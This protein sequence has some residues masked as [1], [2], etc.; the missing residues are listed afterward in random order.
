LAVAAVATIAVVRALTA[1]HKPVLPVSWCRPESLSTLPPMLGSAL[2]TQWHVDVI[3]LVV[4]GLAGLLYA[5]GVVLARRA[6]H[7]WPLQRGVGFLCGLVVCALATNS[8]IAVYDMA[9]FSA[10]MVGHLMLVMLAPVLLCIGR[11][12]ELLVRASADPWSDRLARFFGGRV[13]S[14]VLC[15]PVALATYAAVIVTS[16]LTG[17]MDQ[18]M[19]RPWAGQLEH[20]VYVLV[21]MQFFTLLVGDSTIRWQLTTAARWLLLVLSMAVDTSTGVVLMMSTQPVAMVAVPGFDVNPLADT[22]TAGAIMWVGGDG[23]M[24]AVM[25]WLTISF[26]RQPAMR[27]RD[28]TGL[29]EQARQTVFAAHTGGEAPAVADAGFDDE[30]ANRERYNRWLASLDNHG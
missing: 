20:L 30:E 26:L 25:I 3:A 22:H 18:I 16:H 11:P 2:L 7:A 23:L 17:V 24:A 6:G 9:L 29:L 8:S 4:L 13:V 12:M 10:H 14:L 5:V 21:G 19:Q 15:P 1:P 27:E 28:R